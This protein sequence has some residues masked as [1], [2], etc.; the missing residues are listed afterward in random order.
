MR[1][2]P[3]AHNVLREVPEGPL[4]LMADFAA[5]GRPTA[6]FPELVPRL[7]TPATYW[8]TAPPAF[9]QEG[10]M[11]GDRYGARWLTDVRRDGRPVAGVLG[12][13][14]GAVYAGWLADRIARIQ[15][16][17][18]VVLLDPEPSDKAMVL[19]DFVKLVTSRM[20]NLIGE[21]DAREA[22]AVARRADRDTDDDVLALTEV[23]VDL[24]TRITTTGL[25]QLGEHRHRWEEFMVLFIGYLRWLAGACTVSDFRGWAGADVILSSTPEL[26]LQATPAY[27]RTSLVGTVTNVGVP[28][29]DLL[30]SAETAE[31]LDRLLGAAVGAAADPGRNE[32]ADVDAVQAMS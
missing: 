8:E 12:F 21:D 13:C 16:P 9:G 30:R 2:A 24:C 28:H 14:S 32:G 18:R 23:L 6:Q 11:D 7:R 4:V 5:A 26:G 10:R 27:V 20:G 31:R 22:L 29:F 1:S 19:D 15:P 3:R 17:P 25:V